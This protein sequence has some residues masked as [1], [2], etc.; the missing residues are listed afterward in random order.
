MHQLLYAGVAGPPLFIAV[1]LV[2]GATRRDYVAWRHFG[3]QLALGPGGWVQVVNFLICGS[4]VVL[5]AIGLGQRLQG[6]RGGLI[7][8]ILF[9]IFGLLLLV[10]GL[11]STDPVLGYPPG[12]SELST[13]RGTIHTIAGVITFIL[14]PITCFVMAWHFAAEAGSAAWVAYSV[15]VGLVALFSMITAFGSMGMAQAGRLRNPMPGL[16]Q[17]VAII[18]GWTWIA[19]VA[20]HFL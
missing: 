12:A 7:A 5:F 17:R 20:W 6:T 11:F 8:P 15:V 4:L 16:F 9:A 3:S 10:A 2:A 1:L 14:L 13:A 19:A 18:A